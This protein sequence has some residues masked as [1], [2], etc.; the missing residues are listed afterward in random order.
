MTSPRLA[1][2]RIKT[3]SSSERR[4]ASRE[5]SYAEAWAD[6]GGMQPAILCKIIDISFTGAKLCFW[7]AFPLPNDFIL[8]TGH[9]KHPAHVVWR[10]KD[11]VGVEFDPKTQPYRESSIIEG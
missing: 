7:P 2:R 4:I 1:N 8:H 6:P 10:E 3:P 11:Q 9:T 5:K